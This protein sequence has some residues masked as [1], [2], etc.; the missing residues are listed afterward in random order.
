[1]AVLYQYRIHHLLKVKR[2]E[3]EAWLE[4]ERAQH[5]AALQIEKLRS[6]IAADFHDGIGS[7]LGGLGLEL[8]L[9]LTEDGLT[10]ALEKQIIGL[11]ERVE[12]ISDVRRDMTWIVN[13]QH[14]YLEHLIDRIKQVAYELVLDGRLRVMLPEEIPVL[15]IGM[16]IRGNIFFLVKEAIYNAAKHSKADGIT[17][18]IALDAQRCIFMVKDDGIGFNQHYG[19]R[20]DG[21]NNMS[22]RAAAMGAELQVESQ[23]GEGT[24]IKFSVKMAD[25][26][27]VHASL[28]S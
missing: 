4:V 21:L 27:H 6:D 8:D 28:L 17:V 7:D 1:M 25:L 9:L 3:H 20:G 10:D 15:P 2:I 5:E 26:N 14:D 12:Q 22:M 18:R 16:V 11:R 23:P 24:V 13:T 19:V